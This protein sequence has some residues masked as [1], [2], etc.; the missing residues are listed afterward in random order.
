MMKYFKYAVLSLV[1][2]LSAGSVVIA[3]GVG[4]NGENA[5]VDTEGN[6]ETVTY[7]GQ[8]FTPATNEQGAYNSDYT[9]AD[10][11]PYVEELI[12][13]GKTTEKEPAELCEHLNKLV[14]LYLQNYEDALADLSKHYE[15]ILQPETDL[16][17]AQMLKVKS[18]LPDL[19]ELNPS[20]EGKVVMAQT[21]HN[22]YLGMMML[23]DGAH[24]K[25][26]TPEDTVE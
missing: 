15:D 1:L 16:Q 25:F 26:C 13:E 24:A 8:T 2:V 21:A 5:L 17:V 12:P 7:Y 11:K 20:M 22:Q 14:H 4:S 3:Q 9:W 10:M 19:I 18:G 23:S 6:V